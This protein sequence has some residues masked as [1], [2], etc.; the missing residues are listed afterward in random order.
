[1]AKALTAAAVARL[2]EGAQRR[3]IRDGGC[4]GLYLIIQQS[5]VKSWALRFRKPGGKSAKLT[6]G[7]VDLTNKEVE[8]EP[9]VGAPLTLASARRL[10]IELHRQRAIGKDVVAVRY[11]EKLE[12]KARGAKTF[13]KAA[14]D[15]IEQHAMR[16]TRRWKDRARLLGLRAA[17]EARGL[18]LIPQGLAD[19]WRDR[20]ITEIDGDDVHAIVD[21]VRENGVPGLEQRVVDGP[22]ESRALVMFATLSKLFSWL[23]ERRRIR[24]N[25]CIGVH[26]PAT[27]HAR[28]R[29]LTND[30]I[31][32]FWWAA[33]AERAEF[34]AVLKLLLLT[35][36]RRGEVVGMRRAE[37]SGDFAVWT[38]PGTR[39]KN[40]RAHVVPLS[41][42]ARNIIAGVPT[43]GDIVFT[44]N[45]KS[46]VSCGSKIKRRLDA[47]MKNAPW[48]LHDLRRTAATGMAEIGIPPHIVEAVLNHVSGHKAGVAGIYNRAQ[49]AAEKKVA[50]ER[51]AAHVEELIAGGPATNVVPLYK[52]GP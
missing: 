36:Q 8:A 35:G 51:W 22:S 42:A 29:V 34:T 38:I 21:E 12:R 52:A 17:K 41:A 11:R 4:P 23:V 48:R 16:N 2:K 15:F 14:I 40:K 9:V 49:Y 30:E 45:G 25:P 32:A 31:V 18:E 5:G 43:T 26:R 39:T 46:P 44:T 47:L 1:M 20:P 28:D 10:A 19:R 37:L 33:G 6:L 27:Q 50:L 3:E 13:A 24:Q 7:K